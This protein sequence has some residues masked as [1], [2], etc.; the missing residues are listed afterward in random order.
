MLSKYLILT[1]RI[2]MAVGVVW[3]GWFFY[4][5]FSDNTVTPPAVPAK[6][7][8]AATMDEWRAAPYRDRRDTAADWAVVYIGK[9][10]ATKMPREDFVKLAEGVES[11]VS[12]A[13]SAPDLRSAVG[14]HKA[15]EHAVMC[16]ALMGLPR[17]R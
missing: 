14:H 2:A 1:G 9:D 12:K 7:L 17:A 13:T 11:C 10:V 8:H 6:A 5:K 15:A 3:A 16:M 4:G